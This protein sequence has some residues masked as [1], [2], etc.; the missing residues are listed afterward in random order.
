M[1]NI[2][3]IL[4]LEYVYTLLVVRVS[5]CVCVVKNSK[6]VPCSSEAGSND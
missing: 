6:G 3:D 1:K 4:V 5:W 2:T